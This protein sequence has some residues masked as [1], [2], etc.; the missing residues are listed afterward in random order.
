MV[1]KDIAGILPGI[2]EHKDVMGLAVSHREYRDN[3][4]ATR[5]LPGMSYREHIHWSGFQCQ[6]SN[7]VY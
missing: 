6:Q 3:T 7:N 2:S 1:F 5:G 4:Y